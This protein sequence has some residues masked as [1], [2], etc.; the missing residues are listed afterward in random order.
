MLSLTFCQR[1]RTTRCFYEDN[2]SVHIIPIHRI[3]TAAKQSQSKA[4]R[5]K[6]TPPSDHTSSEAKSPLRGLILQDSPPCFANQGYFKA[7]RDPS[8]PRKLDTTT[9]QPRFALSCFQVSTTFLLLSFCFWLFKTRRRFSGWALLQLEGLL[10]ESVTV[11]AVLGLFRVYCAGSC[12]QPRCLKG[13]RQLRDRLSPNARGRREPR[14]PAS[15]S[16]WACFFQITATFCSF[17]FDYCYFGV[18]RLGFMPSGLG[19]TGMESVE[20]R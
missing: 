7:K 2:G 6:T 17:W 14:I 3:R 5:L 13:M 19:R 4:V 18:L 20:T 11:L 1:L 9:S 15:T 10:L 16:V 8:I 12:S